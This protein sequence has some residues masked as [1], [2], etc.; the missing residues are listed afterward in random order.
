MIFSSKCPAAFIS[1]LENSFVSNDYR[2]WPYNKPSSIKAR[3]LHTAVFTVCRQA[4]T[5]RIAV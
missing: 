2:G 5:A 3:L 1:N 4:L